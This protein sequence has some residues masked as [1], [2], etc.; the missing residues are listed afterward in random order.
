[1]APQHQTTPAR[2]SLSALK[3]GSWSRLF[4]LDVAR[5]LAAQIILAVD[6]VHA[7][8]FIHGDI[9]LA[10]ILVK[11]PPS[12]DH[13]SPEQL[14][15]EYGAP[16]LEP[17][18]RLDENPLPLPAGVPSHAVTPIW[19][20]A[21]SDKITPTEAS[22]L[23][24]DFGE[25]FAY[26]KERKYLSR[27]PL[28][29]RPPE[30]R[31]EPDI[32]LSFSADIWSLACT[33]WCIIAQRPLFEGFMATA[34]DM[35]CEHVD[36][37]GILPPDWWKTWKARGEKFTDDGAPINHNPY[38]SWDD[39]FEDSVQEPRQDRGMQRIDA[40][41]REA[42]FSM[43]RPML[44]FTPGSRPSTRQLLESEWMVK[45]ALPEFDK[46]QRHVLI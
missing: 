37:L 20:G 3:D 7:Q 33:I 27:A 26:P 39:R 13:L 31:F 2:A 6:Y 9:H 4:R 21:V 17:V 36:A 8:G 43:L 40:E 12:F 38:R 46:I 11:I 30:A 32:P 19:L 1:M 14:S 41:E 15:E 45:W 44:S 5:S 29:N 34:D 35:T 25:A 16:E 10:N 18:V 22:I 24:Y 28:V 23:L 42:I